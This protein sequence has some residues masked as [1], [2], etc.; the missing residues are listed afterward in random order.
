MYFLPW[1]GSAESL[2]KML[3]NKMNFKKSVHFVNTKVT[4]QNPTFC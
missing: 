2:N 4:N 3:D 1:D